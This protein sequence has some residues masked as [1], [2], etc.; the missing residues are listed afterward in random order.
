MNR[1]PRVLVVIAALSFSWLAMQAVHEFGHVILGYFLGQK[2]LFV[3][4]LDLQALMEIPIHGIG[5]TTLGYVM[6]DSTNAH[7]L[8]STIQN[9]W[10]HDA[11]Y[12]IALSV[13]VILN[14]KL[15]RW[16]F[17]KPTTIE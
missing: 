4:W 8:S 6:F 11:Y 14:G 1:A 7:T 16:R 3:Q 15:L 17:K 5:G 10:Y 12:L 2:P 13:L 9:V